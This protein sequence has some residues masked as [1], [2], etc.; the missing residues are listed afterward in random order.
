MQRTLIFISIIALVSCTPFARF[1]NP[2]SGSLEIRT[3]QFATMTLEQNQASDYQA[4]TSADGSLS[5][6]N[7]LL[8]GTTLTN[9]NALKLMVDDTYNT[10]VAYYMNETFYFIKYNETFDSS[11]TGA[12]D[13]NTAYVRLLD[14][15]SGIQY[16]NLVGNGNPNSATLF[17]YV[18]QFQLTE[19]MP[20]SIQFSSLLITPSLTSESFVV[21]TTFTAGEAYTILF[22]NMGNTDFQGMQIFDR[23]VATGTSPNPS[24][25][26]T[27]ASMTTGSIVINTEHSSASKAGLAMMA[28]M[29][30][31][32]FAC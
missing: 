27:V 9:N 14:L 11:I 13:S 21:P 4:V 2:L 18:G 26:E 8:N 15:A 31:L 16:L 7:A 23:T 1:I 19:Y 28:I 30:A 24:A 25:N 20:V 22:L 32:L 29:G 10:F 3:D 6:T 5:V 17:Q 12:F